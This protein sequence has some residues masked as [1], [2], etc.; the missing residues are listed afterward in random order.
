MRKRSLP[1]AFLGVSFALVLVAV[2]LALRGVPEHQSFKAFYCA[3]STISER[4]DP[5]LVEPLRTCERRV[6]NNAMTANLVEPAPLPGYAVLPFVVLAKLPPVSAAIVFS[7]GLAVAVSLCALM[8]GSMLRRSAAAI[9]LVL[10]PLAILNAAYGEIAPY[11]LLALC[12]AAYFLMKER[13]VA[14]AIAVCCALLQPNV[15]LPS[16]LAVFVFAPRTRVPIAICC[17]VLAA[18]SVGT[19]GFARNIEYVTAVLPL[20]AYSEL[21]AN[22]QYS[23]SRILFVAGVSSEGAMLISRIA[24]A[25]AALIS[26]A[27]SG[28]LAAR[29]KSASLLALLPAALI[30]TGGIYVHDI[31]LLFAVPAAL[32][33]WSRVRGTSYAPLAIASLLMLVNVWSQRAGRA[34]LAVDAVAAAAVIAIVVRGP[35]VRRFALMTTA[36]IAMIGCMVLLQKIEPPAAGEIA[37]A[38]FSAPATELAPIAWAAYLRATPELMRVEF[39]LKTPTYIALL[40]LYVVAIGASVRDKTNL[41]TLD[42][43]ESRAPPL[44]TGS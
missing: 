7:A 19:L 43:D 38:A 29:W 44:A 2:F 42:R 36:A 28:M 35:I 9:L 20:Q 23:L 11:A 8:L 21:V 4:Q 41:L 26:V 27:L 39:A 16:V 1:I 5:Y 34:S 32:L 17:A 25:A 37:S 15:A 14:A 40:F 18:V 22:D 6:S 24:Y 12:A 30:L 3:G 10:C 31:Q 13:W 33:I